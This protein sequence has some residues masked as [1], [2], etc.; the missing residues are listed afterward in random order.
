VGAQG[1]DR[2]RR[3]VEELG[4][5]EAGIALTAIGIEDPE[6][7]S[8]VGR[9]IPIAGDDDLGPLTHDVASEPDPVAAAKLEPKRGRIGD[10][11][12]QPTT[13]GRWLEDE[14]AG[15]RPP[16]ER[17][18]TAQSIGQPIRSPGQRRQV[19]HEQIDRP[20]G[21][22]TAADGERFV[23]IGGIDDDQ[24][25]ELDAPADRFNR[26]EAAPGVDPGDDPADGLSL[27]CHPHR[28]RRLAR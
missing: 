21:E 20:R 8:P 18:Q 3:V 24:P 17:G 22:Q 11:P 5:T 15:V 4:P 23:E 10:G 2:L 6:L 13:E 26:I 12:G 16:G 7:G 9:A 14:E 27:G 28:D 25:L 19:E 1:V